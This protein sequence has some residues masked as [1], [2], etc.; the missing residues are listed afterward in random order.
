MEGSGAGAWTWSW[1]VQI[2]A[3]PDPDPGCPKTYG[4]GTLVSTIP[5][6]DYPE[7]VAAPAWTPRAGH[8]T[9]NKSNRLM[10]HPPIPEPEI[11]RKPKSG[12]K[13]S[14]TSTATEVDAGEW[15]LP[16]QAFS[17]FFLHQCQGPS[18]ILTAFQTLSWAKWPYKHYYGCQH[19]HDLSHCHCLYLYTSLT[20]STWT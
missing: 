5:K 18:D 17:R 14:G 11:W 2:I 20:A 1:P 6:V 10:A 13:E 9:W 3:D 12:L 7:S 19:S 4:S 8:F 15:Q 16:L